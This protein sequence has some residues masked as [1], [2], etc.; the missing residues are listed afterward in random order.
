[1]QVARITSG[2]TRQGARLVQSRALSQAH[3]SGPPTTRVSF[4]VRY[5]F[6]ICAI[7]LFIQ[8][9]SPGKGH[10]WSRHQ[11][12][13]GGCSNLGVGAHQGLPG[14]RITL[15]PYYVKAQSHFVLLFLVP[16]LVLVV[17]SHQ[18]IDKS[19]Q[20]ISYCT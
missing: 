19:P 9:I 2:L 5:R 12:W 8:F 10:P 11:R 14:W 16:T 15:Q 7:F 1:M 20:S 3:M 6:I 18:V 17:S 13:F 4:V